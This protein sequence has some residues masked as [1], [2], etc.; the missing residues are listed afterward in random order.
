MQYKKKE[1]AD[2]LLEEAMAEFLDKGYRTGSITA[3]AERA[4]VPIGNLYRYF[5]GKQGILD[6]LVKQF[7]QTFPSMIERLSYVDKELMV[8][9]PQLLEYLTTL[10]QNLIDQYGKVMILLVDKCATTR[11]EDFLDKIIDQVANIVHIK[12]YEKFNS[13]MDRLISKIASKAFIHSIIDI[14][15]LELPREKNEEII[16]RVLNFYFHDLQERI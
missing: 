4:G 1:T 10:V 7:Y 16:L 13:D 14:L 6:A 15:R 2:K 8:D 9:V 12:L 3:I 5:D 11:Y